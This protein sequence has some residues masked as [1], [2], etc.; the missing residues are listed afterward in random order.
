M[1]ASEYKALRMEAAQREIS[2]SA[3]VRTLILA[4]LVELGLREGVKAAK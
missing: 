4:H 2:V 3:Y 1:G